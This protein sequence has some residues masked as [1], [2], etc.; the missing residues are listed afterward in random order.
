MQYQESNFD[1]VCRLME[2]EGIFYYFEHSDGKHT[3]V[4]ADD[5]DGY[6]KCAGSTDVGMGLDDTPNNLRN[7]TFEESLVTTGYALTD[8]NFEIPSTDLYVKTGGGVRRLWSTIILAT[9]PKERR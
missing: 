3:M 5:S 2:D 4:L 6:R 1:F 9:T 7:C 8:Y